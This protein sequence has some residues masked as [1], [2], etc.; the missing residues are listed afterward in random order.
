MTG[1]RA[2]DRLVSALIVAGGLVVAG[3]G[4]STSSEVP[5]V[6]P[7]EVTLGRGETL[8]FEASVPVRWEVEEGAAGGSIAADGTYT[9]PETLGTF[10]VVASSVTNAFGR[11]RATITT[12]TTLRLVA[13]HPGAQGTIDGKGSEAR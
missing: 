1:R 10:H 3:C 9:A 4:F 11:V 5:S 8:K 2:A 12:V 13:G 7:A 6:T